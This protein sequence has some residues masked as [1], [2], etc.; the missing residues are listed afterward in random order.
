MWT[1]W[2]K[3][4]VVYSELWEDGHE[5]TTEKLKTFFKVRARQRREGPDYD[6]EIEEAVGRAEP[7]SIDVDSRVR[8]RKRVFLE[9][10]RREFGEYRRAYTEVDDVLERTNCGVLISRTFL[11]AFE[12]NRFLNWVR[13]THVKGDE[14]WQ[15][16]L[17]RNRES[18][19]PKSW[20][21]V[22]LGS[23]R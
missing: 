1:Q 2:K 4:R 10:L 21:L 12:T 17:I 18:G 16:A 23:T 19:M 7:R 9:D 3:I 8:S 13:L 5:L 6:A 20:G 15:T 22:V 11:P 14:A